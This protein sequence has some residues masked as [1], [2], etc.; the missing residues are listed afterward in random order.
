MCRHTQVLIESQ[1]YLEILHINT[2]TSTRI[3]DLHFPVLVHFSSVSRHRASEQ[4]VL[5][6]FYSVFSFQILSVTIIKAKATL[7]LLLVNIL[8]VI[9]TLYI[10]RMQS[11]QWHLP[12]QELHKYQ[13]GKLFTFSI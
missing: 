4:M 12:L 6:L 1:G 2:S 7:D 3:F 8:E 10:A 5:T 13:K 9:S 11:H